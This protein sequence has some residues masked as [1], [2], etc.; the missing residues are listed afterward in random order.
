M[1]VDFR[2]VTLLRGGARTARFERVAALAIAD[3]KVI[4]DDRKHHRMRAVQETP[5]FNRLEVHVGNDVSGALAIPAKP[6]AYFWLE[7]QRPGHCAAV[8]DQLD[9]R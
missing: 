4:P 3:I 2:V 5:V 9:R 7:S 6:V 8:Y 1:R